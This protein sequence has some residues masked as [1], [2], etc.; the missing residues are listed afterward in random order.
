MKVKVSKRGNR[1]EA[2]PVELPGSPPVGKG[3]S[4][5]EALGDF[6]HQYRAELGVEIELDGSARDAEQERRDAALAQSL[7]QRETAGEADHVRE[8]DNRDC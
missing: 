1:F 8:A 5:M 7:G 6:L 3:D 2:D 4:I